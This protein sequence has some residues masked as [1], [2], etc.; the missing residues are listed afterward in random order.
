MSTYD[1]NVIIIERNSKLQ[2]L[3]RSAHESS[4]GR[5]VGGKFIENIIS[6]L[7]FLYVYYI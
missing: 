1:Q 4:V 2:L 3:Q 6:S 7:C 5:L